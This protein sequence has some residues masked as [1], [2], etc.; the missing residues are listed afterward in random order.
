M[1]QHACRTCLIREAPELSRMGYVPRPRG[2]C[3]RAPAHVSVAGVWAPMRQDHALPRT[4]SRSG[5]AGAHSGK[6]GGGGGNSAHGEN[7]GLQAGGSGFSANAHPPRRLRLPEEGPELQGRAAGRAG[8]PPSLARERRPLRGGCGRGGSRL[9]TGPGRPQARRTGAGRARPGGRR[10]RTHITGRGPGPH[11]GSPGADR[12]GAGQCRPTRSLPAKRGSP[13]RRRRRR[14]ADRLPALAPA[15]TA[16]WRWRQRRRPG[17]CQRTAGGAARLTEAGAEPRGPAPG[18][19]LDLSRAPPPAGWRR[20][21]ATRRGS[22]MRT[23]P[24]SPR[25]P[26]IPPLVTRR[27]E[28]CDS[29]AGWEAEFLRVPLAQA[30]PA[31]GPHASPGEGGKGR[32][33]LTLNKAP[34]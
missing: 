14:L 13:W 18:P 10:P 32:K 9:V 26:G 11:P 20:D 12:R 6:S 23:P 3:L 25:G 31:R 4:H 34:L 5:F 19:A 21:P 15:R 27:S 24:G 2:L 28:C 8:C 7:G 1:R 16:P 30:H 33:G 29:V 22:C 17:S